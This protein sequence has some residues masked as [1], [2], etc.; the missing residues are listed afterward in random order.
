MILL[1]T[2]SMM[3]FTSLVI[4]DTIVQSKALYSTGILRALLQD[5]IVRKSVG[6]VGFEF[7]S[8]SLFV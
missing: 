7:H 6:G 8:G 4:S 5:V 3:E 2:V 1:D